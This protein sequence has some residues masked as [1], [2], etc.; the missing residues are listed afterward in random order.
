M[1]KYSVKRL[2]LK[3]PAIRR[4]SLE[5]LKKAYDASVLGHRGTPSDAVPATGTEL[6]RFSG[7]YEGYGVFVL[8]MQVGFG[9]L[10][11]EN[12][13]QYFLSFLAVLPE[14][15][16]DGA[17]RRLALGMV[18]EALRRKANEVSVILDG[19]DR[20]RKNWLRSL[21]FSSLKREEDS[22]IQLSLIFNEDYRKFLSL[23]S[24]LDRYTSLKYGFFEVEQ[25]PYCD[26]FQT[27]LVLMQ[28]FS[29]DR[30]RREEDYHTALILEK[31]RLNIKLRAVSNYLQENGIPNLP[32][33]SGREDVISEESLSVKEAALRAGMGWLGK[34]DRV[35]NRIYGARM[36]C[37]VIYID[38]DFP[39]NREIRKNACGE[40]RK[41][42]DLCPA[43]C[44]KNR[45]W[46][47]R[48][49]R[50][51]IIDENVCMSFRSEG[52]RSKG[53]YDDCDLCVWCCP[54][55]SK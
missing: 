42:V 29:F 43:K 41:C 9:L 39:V 8:N 24:M 7:K 54:G 49:S 32:R 40:C 18:R 51:A 52:Y 16:H 30:S 20:V 55:Q 33:P 14:Y 3:Q 31:E 48:L 22:R 19:G 5:I 13:E 37:C 45:K 2:D 47:T 26:S 46:N 17:G 38:A 6:L 23:C 34:N 25:E 53:R 36:L 10:S 27:G 44:L 4:R 21:G 35:V 1:L 11:W 12:P 15:Q 50:K 28:P